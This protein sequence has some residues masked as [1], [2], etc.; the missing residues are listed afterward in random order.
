MFYKYAEESS[1][2]KIFTLRPAQTGSYIHL[3]QK[4]RIIAFHS[5]MFQWDRKS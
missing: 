4:K 3:D 1:I 5:Q 2:D